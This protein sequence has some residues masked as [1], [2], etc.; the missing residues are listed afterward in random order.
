MKVEDVNLTLLSDSELSTM[1]GN[2]MQELARRDAIR[3]ALDAARRAAADY[4]AA[5]KRSPA[6]DFKTLALDALVGPGERIMLEDTEYKNVS[7]QWLSP[8][9]QGPVGFWRGWVKCDG[10]GNVVLGAHKP[11]SPG[12]LVVEGDQCKH[13]GRVWRCLK[14]HETS[15]ALAPDLAPALWQAIG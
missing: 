3:D 11:W 10:K 7:G 8:H 13:V 5:V 15:N 14:K 9:T 12:M 2:V 6:K 1:Y 4:E